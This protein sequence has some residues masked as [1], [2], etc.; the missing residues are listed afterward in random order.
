MQENDGHPSFVSLLANLPAASVERGKGKLHGSTVAVLRNLIVT[1][2][3]APGTRLNERELCEQLAVSRTPIREAIKTLMQD[4]LLHASPNHS[5]IVSELDATEVEALIDVLMVIEGL[6]GELAARHVDDVSIAEIG[7]L[8]Y[9]MVLHHSRNELPAYFA[10]NKAFHRKI[11]ELSR[12]P[13]LIWIWDLLALRV[14][15]ARYSSNRWPVR[16]KT[17]IQEH[18]QILDA[19]TARDANLTA[20]QMRDHVKSGLSGLVELLKAESV[21]TSTD[22]AQRHNPSDVKR[23][24]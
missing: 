6:A 3:L 17:A 22:N 10:A 19:L 4:G 9:Q 12:N 23:K 14:D 8:H 16:W 20:S 1:G 11:V 7:V 5:A 24:A 2:A 13:I 18:Q 15:R 21:S